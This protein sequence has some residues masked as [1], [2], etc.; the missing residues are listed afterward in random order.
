MT[1]IPGTIYGRSGVAH[2]SDVDGLRAVA[3]LCVLGFHAFARWLPGGFVGVDVFFVISGYLISSII[4]SG[5]QRGCFSFTDFYAR[6]I[7][8]LFPALIVVLAATLLL[9]WYVLLTD[10]FAQLGRHVVGGTGFV[11]NLMLWREAGYFDRAADHKPLL[12]LWSLGVEEQFYIIWPLL[13]FLAWRLRTRFGALVVIGVIAVTSFVLNVDRVSGHEAATF[14]LPP[15]RFW[16]L[17]A[18]SVLGYPYARRNAAPGPGTGRPRGK[19]WS[20]WL[21]RAAGGGDLRAIV[22]LALIIGAAIGL[23]GTVLYP[24]WWALLPTIG[25]CLLISAGNGGWINR[26]V[27]GSRPMIFIGLIS[28]PLYLWHW[29]L[30]SFERI[31][32]PV[33]GSAVDILILLAIAFLL[34]WA[35]YQFIERPVRTSAYRGPVLLCLIVLVTVV[36]IFG[37]LG[38]IG[39]LQPRSANFGL[40]KLVAASAPFFPGPDLTPLGPE[41]APL[42]RQGGNGR[43]VLFVGDSFVE[44]YY[45]RVDRVLQTHPADTRSVVFATSGG[46]PP[47]P[48]V[49]EVHHPD[50]TQV[51]QRAIAYAKLANVDAIVI[52]AFWVQ[53]FLQPDPRYTYLFSAAPGHAQLLTDPGVQD[54][55]LSALAAMIYGFRTGGKDVYLLLQGP[56]E[57]AFDPRRLIQR[58]WG[59]V[60]FHVTGPEIARQSIVQAMAPLMAKLRVIA[61]ATGSRVIDPMDALCGQVCT[62]MSADGVP[63]YNGAHGHLN[64]N[65]VRNHITFLDPILYLTTPS[66]MGGAHGVETGH[67]G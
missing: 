54:R 11:A 36:S 9:G 19:G 56:A 26:V 30:L 15:S 66:P 57:P 42:L 48:D 2:R 12:H 62:A 8:R 51:L 13:L 22:G 47:I 28:Y 44:H 24:G 21:T 27:L 50:C 41:W 4:F 29:P 46:C 37:Y 33:G 59:N 20:G 3:I 53:Y 18:G 58:D 45:P 35:T 61:G 10:E 43:V 67:K 63:I 5:L 17:L 60:S 23:N 39:R 49:V 38:A 55:A 16:E 25:T 14:Y 7:R 52:G 65:F 31:V 34:A 64:A 40:K 1:Q 6:R 32:N